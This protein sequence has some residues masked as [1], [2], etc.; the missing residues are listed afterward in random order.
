[1]RNLFDQYSQPENRLT[2]ALASVLHYDR[3]L[4]RSF[5]AAFGPKKPPAALSLTVTEQSLPG[6]P[7]YGADRKEP[8]GLP[9]ALI[10]DEQG[11]ALIIESKVNDVLTKDQLRR[12]GRTVEKCGF[13]AIHGLAITVRASGFR[14][15]GWRIIGWKDVYSWANNHYHNSQWARFLIDYLNVAEARMADDEYLKEGTIT[16]FSG[17]SFDPYTYLEGK[18]VLRLLTQKLRD[19]RAFI[20]DMRLAKDTRRTRF[21]EQARLWDFISFMLPDGTV[22]RF[23]KYPHCTVGLGP[24]DAEAMITFPNGMPR[25]LL[26]RLHGASFDD[27][28]HSLDLAGRALD[29]SLK[30]LSAYRPIV[31][32]MQRR[33]KSQSAV[34]V[35]DAIAEFDLRTVD[36]GDDPAMGRPVKQQREWARMAY[37]LL[38]NK[39]ANIQFQ[40][41]VLFDH[42]TGELAGKNA[43]DRFVATFKALRPFASPVLG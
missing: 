11:W 31:R 14:L 32:V 17:I 25:R 2:H 5:L 8:Q 33:Y 3:G 21:T 20:S 26:K 24:T 23:E 4:L 37:D 34:P 35:R 16:E 12:H 10:Y 6:R 19:N 30:G 28:A 36:G 7:D 22:P 42:T 39:H 29:R 1:M 41:G 40:I 18:R 9:D 13:D 38:T 15:D 27:L 43:D